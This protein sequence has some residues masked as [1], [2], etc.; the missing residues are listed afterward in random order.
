MKCYTIPSRSTFHVWQ[1]VILIYS[2]VILV[3]FKSLKKNEFSDGLRLIF[4][5]F[6]V[7]SHNYD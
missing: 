2:I 3:L 6:S 1:N 5:G 7:I 4:L